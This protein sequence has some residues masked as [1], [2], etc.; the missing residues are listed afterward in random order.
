M[1]TAYPAAGGEGPDGPSPSAGATVEDGPLPPEHEQGPRA[2]RP[3]RLA[4]GLLPLVLGLVALV[5]SVRMGIGDPRDPGAGLWPLLTA[6]AIVA[7]AIALLIKERDEHDY[8]RFTRGALFNMLGVLSL[9]AYVLVFRLIGFEVATLVVTA[10]WLKVLGGESWRI[11]AAVSLGV[12]VSLYVLFV[13]LLG[14]S[15]PRLI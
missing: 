2:G 10:F 14:A 12:T 9:V 1:S 13:S 8:E 7:F 4:G 15:L 6:L 3:V 5:A 11:T